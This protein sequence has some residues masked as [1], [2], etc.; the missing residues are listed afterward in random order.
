M[1][2]E[3]SHIQVLDAC[4][5]VNCDEEWVEVFETLKDHLF[6]G[7]CDAAICSESA[8]VLL[9][10]IRSPELTKMALK[11]SADTLLK[12]LKLLHDSEVDEEC[13]TN[14]YS[15]LKALFWESEAQK[16]KE[17]VYK[18]LKNFSESFLEI[19]ENS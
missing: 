1:N 11:A 3:E 13:Q 9:K 5:H 4:L 16:I 12:T 15:F 6:V 18:V 14:C 7:L 2:L 17:F 8:T 10:L 19:F